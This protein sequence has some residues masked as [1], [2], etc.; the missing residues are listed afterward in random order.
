MSP[1][2]EETQFKPTP[3]ATAASGDSDEEEDMDDEVLY[4]EFLDS[5]DIGRPHVGRVRFLFSAEEPAKRERG[6]CTTMV[7]I[8]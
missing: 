2:A 5:Q 3:P 6:R 1:S 8:S 7:L 4:D